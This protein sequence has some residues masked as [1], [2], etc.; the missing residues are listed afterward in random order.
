MEVVT[1]KYFG[2]DP[3]EFENTRRLFTYWL[4]LGGTAELPSWKAVN[5]MSLHDIAPTMF[6]VDLVRDQQ[7]VSYCYRYVGTKIV[8]TFGIEATGKTV[9]EVYEGER[10]KDIIDAYNDVVDGRQPHC[11]IRS[12]AN[13]DREFIKFAVLTAPLFEVDGTVDKLIGVKEF[14]AGNGST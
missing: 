14:L 6:V 7:S 9:E 11:G 2:I 3:R 10:R 1:E 4:E 13:L 12:Q 8:D 5:L